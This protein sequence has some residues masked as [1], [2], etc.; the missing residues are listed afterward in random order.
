MKEF[1]IKTFVSSIAV[2]TGSYLLPGVSIKDITYAIIVALVLSTLNVLI[3]PLFVLLTLPLTIF[4]LG[5]F[6]LVINAIMILLADSLLPG[7]EVAGFWWAVVF[8]L[9]LTFINWLIESFVKDLRGIK[10]KSKY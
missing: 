1:L 3:K 4:S 8:S 6:L 9:L 5:L 7:F 10:N 2:M